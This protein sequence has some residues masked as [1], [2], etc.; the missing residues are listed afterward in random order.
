MDIIFNCPYCDQELA[1]DPV[2]SGTEIE[3]PSCAKTILIPAADADGT[4][5]AATAPAVEA[6]PETPPAAAPAGQAHRVMKEFTVPQR[7]TSESLIQKANKP[8]DVAAKDTGRHLRVKTIKHGDCVEVGHDKF[9]EI[10]TNFLAKIGDDNFVSI[11][12]VSYTHV[13]VGTQKFIADF[14]VVI[15]YKG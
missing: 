2:D 14:A 8:L 13:D 7:A 15:V 4:R 12:P 10:T 5:S 1:A 3:C 11:T 9:D 6:A